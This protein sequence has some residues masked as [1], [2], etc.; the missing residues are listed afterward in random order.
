MRIRARMDTMSSMAMADDDAF[1]IGVTSICDDGMCH[2]A[3]MTHTVTMTLVSTTMFDFAAAKSNMTALSTATFLSTMTTTRLV[4][5]FAGTAVV[6]AY[7]EGRRA[8][9]AAPLPRLLPSPPP[10]LS[11]NARRLPDSC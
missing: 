2:L 10:P 11:L 7:L 6:E 5:T 4:L 9:A 1:V 3:A 8:A